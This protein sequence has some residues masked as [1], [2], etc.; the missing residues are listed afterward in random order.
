[1][2]WCGRRRTVLNCIRN[3]KT[4][5]I[6]RLYYIQSG[7]DDSVVAILVD[8]ALRLLLEPLHNARRPPLL[9]ITGLVILAACSYRQHVP[10]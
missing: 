1:M 4:R 6:Y 3:N 2:D 9:Q 8:D 5:E 7:F 10:T